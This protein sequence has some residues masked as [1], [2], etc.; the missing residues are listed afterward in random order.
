VFPQLEEQ[1]TFWTP[2]DPSS[3]DRLDALVWAC[4]Y[5]IPELTRPP[6]DFA[7]GWAERRAA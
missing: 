1:M 4:A 7:K 5:L 3:P 6:A 2:L